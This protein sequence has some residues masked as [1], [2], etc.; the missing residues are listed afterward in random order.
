MLIKFFTPDD[1]IKTLITE[2]FTPDRL[3]KLPS[4][5]GLVRYD[6]NLDPLIKDL[7]RSCKI[8]YI[9]VWKKSGSIY[10]IISWATEY[11]PYHLEE[12]YTF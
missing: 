2:F 9:K 10:V 6:I 5:Y 8:H 11:P 12:N 7:V 3:R 4:G 1:R